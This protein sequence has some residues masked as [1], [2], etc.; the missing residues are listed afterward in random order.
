MYFHIHEKLSEAYDKGL[1]K[2]AEVWDKLGAEAKA[3]FDQLAHSQVVHDM[4]QD[5]DAL[6][7]KLAREADRVRGELVHLW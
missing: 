5:A 6:A 2:L 4:R 7:A 1:A 3:R